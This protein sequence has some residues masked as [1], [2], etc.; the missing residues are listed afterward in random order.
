MEVLKTPLDKASMSEVTTV[1]FDIAKNVFHAHGADAN[2]R[3]Q[4]SLKISRTKLLEFFVRQPRCLEALETCGV[5]ITG[6][7]THAVGHKV[8]L[9]PPTY[10]KPFVKRVML[11]PFVAD[12]RAYRELPRTGRRQ[13]ICKMAVLSM[14]RPKA[15]RPHPAPFRT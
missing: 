7:A 8:K 12:A 5:P 4:F 3:A 1:G 11:Y 13:T 2:G 15:D 6:L 9:V 14:L 10:V